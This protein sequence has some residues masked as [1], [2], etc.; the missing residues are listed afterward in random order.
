MTYVFD[1]NNY[2]V[3]SVIYFYICTIDSE[4][5]YEKQNQKTANYT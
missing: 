2:I 1:T 4:I 3:K 5:I